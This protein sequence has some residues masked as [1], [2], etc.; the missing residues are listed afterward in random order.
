M[1]KIIFYGIFPLFLMGCNYNYNEISFKHESE[2]SIFDKNLYKNMDNDILFSLSIFPINGLHYI[3]FPNDHVIFSFEAILES[4]NILNNISIKSYEITIEK[5]DL[6]INKEFFEDDI[7]IRIIEKNIG[8]R[9]KYEISFY[10]ENKIDQ[11]INNKDLIL[12]KDN[13]NL[14]VKIIFEYEINGEVITNEIVSKFY[15]NFNRKKISRWIVW[16]S[17]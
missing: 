1:K 5:D 10:S 11:I 13:K 14:L 16:M 12:F 6:I 15:S 4:I 8:Q 2:N 7:F 3:L 9:N 17:I